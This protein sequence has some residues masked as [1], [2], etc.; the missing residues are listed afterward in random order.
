[1]WKELLIVVTLK[2][3]KKKVEGEGGYGSEKL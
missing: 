2:V 3:K 1:M